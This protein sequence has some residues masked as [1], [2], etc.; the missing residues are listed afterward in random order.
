MAKSATMTKSLGGYFTEWC[1]RKPELPVLVYVEDGNLQYR[2]YKELYADVLAWSK[3]FQDRKIGKGERIAFIAPKCLEHFNFF[4]A[5]WYLGIIAVPVCET[6]G[7][8]EMGF[9][10]RDS[11][12]ALVIVEKAW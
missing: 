5:C 9:I 8:L 4:Y 6:L 2:S 10:L 7:D 3:F 11:D 1:S 12:P